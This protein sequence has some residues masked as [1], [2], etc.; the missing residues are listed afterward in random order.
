[1]EREKV[2]EESNRE[3]KANQLK[4]EELERN[5]TEVNYRQLASKATIEQLKREA[6]E[7]ELAHQAAIE[8][9]RLDAQE[10]ELA[11]QVVIERELALRVEI[12]N[13]RT[14]NDRLSAR[15]AV[16]GKPQHLNEIKL[17][18]QD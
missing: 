8:Q 18:I 17:T 9:V 5:I 11:H 4:L 13:I 6:R 2:F 16:I 1:M 3:Q 10:H 14:E 12:I 15:L 7:S